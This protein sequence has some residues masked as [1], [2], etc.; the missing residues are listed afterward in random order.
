MATEMLAGLLGDQ[1]RHL[2]ALE[3]W[4]NIPRPTE[5][6]AL[7]KGALEIVTRGKGRYV[8]GIKHDGRELP[9]IL[10]HQ[11]EENQGKGAALRTGFVDATSDIVLTQD[12]DL[13][14]D[15]AEYPKLLAPILDGKADVVYGSRFIGSEAHRVLKARW[16]YGT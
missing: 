13:E 7:A 15:P 9:R 10:L 2:A 4:Y 12:A 8:A 3:A 1:G 14:Y 5:G 6:E 16:P 11:H